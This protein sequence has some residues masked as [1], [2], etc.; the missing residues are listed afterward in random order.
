M[1][2]LTPR[3]SDRSTSLD[4]FDE[5]DRLRNRLLE[6]FGGP[7][8][9]AGGWSAAFA[10]LEEKD[11]AFVVN[12]EVPG[13]GRDDVRIELEGRR[14]SVHAEREEEEREGVIRR[15][16]RSSRHLH[17]EV[18]LPAEVEQ[19]NVEASIEKGVLTIRLPKAEQAER[20]RIDIR[21]D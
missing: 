12:V 7:S 15:S 2:G 9:L 8:G 21:Q 17:H 5:F 11:D 1:N 16:R 14:L 20:R 10:D 6:T 13:F 18:V 4:L 19:D 3:S